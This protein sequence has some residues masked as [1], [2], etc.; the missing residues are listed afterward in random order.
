MWEDVFRCGAGRLI[1]AL[2]L[3]LRLFYIVGSDRSVV[4]QNKENCQISLFLKTVGGEAEF[5]IPIRE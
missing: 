5:P 4:L 3:F 1:K 2:L